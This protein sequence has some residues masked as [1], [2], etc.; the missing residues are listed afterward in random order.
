M[1]G[2]ATREANLHFPL[3]MKA[4]LVQLSGAIAG[5]QAGLVRQH[6]PR[7]QARAHDLQVRPFPL[8]EQSSHVVL[9]VT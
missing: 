5:A 3:G 1:V 7:H 2:H 9:E 6:L 4:L 8:S